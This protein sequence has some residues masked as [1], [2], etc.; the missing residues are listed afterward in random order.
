MVNHVVL[1][2]NLGSDPEVRTFGDQ[3]KVTRLSVATHAI[4]RKWSGESERQTEW[5]QVVAWAALG[6]RFYFEPQRVTLNSA[7]P[8][9]PIT[10]IEPPNT[11]RSD[12]LAAFSG[13]LTRSWSLSGATTTT[14]S[15][16]GRGD[17]R[18]R[19]PAPEMSAPLPHL[20]PL[21]SYENSVH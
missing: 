6:E 7:L 15:P 13:T 5:H 4:V 9:T 18:A 12:I 8:T 3:Q 11:S 10:N 2:G 16:A 21:R 19:P 14:L 17:Q 20:P 1:V